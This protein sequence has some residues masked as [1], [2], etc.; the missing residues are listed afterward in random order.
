MGI[1][2]LFLS[3]TLPTVPAGQAYDAYL[4]GSITLW[5]Q[6]VSDAEQVAKQSD[7]VE[8]AFALLVTQYGVLNATMKDQDEDVFD[9]HIDAAEENAEALMEN[10]TFGSEAKAIMSGLTGLKI[11]YSPW[12]GMFLGPKSSSL[13]TEALEEMPESAIVQQLYGNH[14]NFTPQMWGGDPDNAIEAYNK[15][16]SI[17][18][19]NQ[20]TSNWMYLDAHVWLG[21]VQKREGRNDEAR[22]AW[23]KVFEVEPD[24]RWV[25]EGLLPALAAKSNQ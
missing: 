22:E 24:F 8:D 6:A 23:T 11:A 13:I 17:Y 1:A 9:R 5:E 16:I 25:K 12:K 3:F 10:S 15:A 14:Q 2:L 19:E 7:K 20:N 21:M 18:E 4:S